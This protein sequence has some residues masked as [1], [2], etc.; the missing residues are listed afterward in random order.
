MLGGNFLIRNKMKRIAFVIF[1]FLIFSI[2]Y[3]TNLY[4]DIT[5]QLIKLDSLYKKGSISKEEYKKAKSIILKMEDSTKKNKKKAK[6]SKKAERILKTVEIKKYKDNIGEKNM[7]MMEMTI[8][9]FRIY[10]HRPGG[11]KIRRISDNK[12]LMTI[13]DKLKFNHYNNS[14]DLIKV[15]VNKEDKSKPMLTLKIKKIPV[16]RWEGRYVKKHRATFYQVVALGNKPFHYYI[17]IESKGNPVALNMSKFNR[18]IDKA[19]A[20]AKI[21]LA[22]KY[23]VSIEQINQLMKERENKVI[24]ELEQVIGE[25]KEKI[26]EASLDNVMEDAI[27][28]QLAEELEAT[29]GAALAAEFVSAIEEAAGEAVDQALEDALAAAIDEAVALAIEEGISKAAI[30]AGIAAYLA[31]LAAGKSEAQALAEGEAACGC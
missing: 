5:D 7:E 23:D 25:E 11:I 6:S 20:K 24:S 10:T 31:A 18:Q 3:N 22:A 28:K 12:Q 14:E 15:I 8:G 9:D 26:M 16:L 21:E 29:I 19:V 1:C 4:S 2:N 13:T 30:E 27:N 17:K